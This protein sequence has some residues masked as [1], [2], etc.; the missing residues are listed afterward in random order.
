LFYTTQNATIYNEING[1]STWSTTSGSGDYVDIFATQNIG[2]TN[3][4]SLNM[5]DFAIA[6]ECSFGSGGTANDL[7]T[8]TYNSYILNIGGTSLIAGFQPGVNSEDSILF[9]TSSLIYGNQLSSTTLPFNIEAALIFDRGNTPPENFVQ[10][11]VNGSLN[12]GYLGT[13]AYLRIVTF[14][15]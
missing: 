11:D 8:D 13:G 12:A 2:I 6:T 5:I 1:V 4:K 14:T 3:T 10:S 9:Q 15:P 7:N